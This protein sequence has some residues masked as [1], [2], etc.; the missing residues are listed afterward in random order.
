MP[1]SERRRDDRQ[2]DEQMIMQKE[3]RDEWEEVKNYH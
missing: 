1:V 3:E 2:R